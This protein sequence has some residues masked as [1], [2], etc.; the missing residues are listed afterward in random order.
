MRLDQVHTVLRLSVTLEDFATIQ[1]NLGELRRT[2]WLP[3]DHTLAPCMLLTDLEIVFDILEPAGQKLHYLRRRTE[4]ATHMVTMGDEIDHLGL[5]LANG[6][7]IGESEFGGVALHLVEMSKEIDDFCVARAEG[8]KVRKPRLRLSKWWSDI[9]ASVEQRAFH[10]WT[11]VYNIL[12][13]LAPE[14]Q[15]EAEKM[16]TRIKTNVRANSKD[17]LHQCSVVVIPT[18]SKT[19]ALALYAFRD[20]DSDKRRERME[21][22]ALKT[23]DHPNVARCLVLA[24]NIDRGVYPYATLAVVSR[25]GGRDQSSI[26]DLLVY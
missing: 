19:S 23:F 11:D 20:A 18:P 1:T 24:V 4:L 2:G 5:Y 9:C 12:L 15:E 25:G 10:R 22:V 21:S 8:V 6:F 17:P 16:F 13:T 14:E 7:N 3:D 26:D